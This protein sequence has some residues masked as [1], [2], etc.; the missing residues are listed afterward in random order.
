MAFPCLWFLCVLTFCL[1][2]VSTV[3]F[4]CYVCLTC[5]PWYCINLNSL[6]SSVRAADLIFLSVPCIG[7]YN[8]G[9][10]ALNVGF[11]IDT[12]LDL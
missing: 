3:N 5:F 9:V 7:S 4:V 12:P 2:S 6:S 8:H 10:V 1:F 11:I